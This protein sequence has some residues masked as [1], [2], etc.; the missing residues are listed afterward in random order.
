MSLEPHTAN[1]KGAPCVCA[2]LCQH[3]GTHASVPGTLPGILHNNSRAVLQAAGSCWRLLL[4][5]HCSH[6]SPPAPCARQSAD[7]N[8]AMPP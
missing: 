3:T 5:Q 4:T 2:C 1:K 8:R 6:G 7:P